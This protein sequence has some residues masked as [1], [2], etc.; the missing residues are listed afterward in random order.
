MGTCVYKQ[1]EDVDK[2]IIFVDIVLN[3]IAMLN[4]VVDF[5]SSGDR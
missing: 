2:A 3:L 4:V 1:G 5:R